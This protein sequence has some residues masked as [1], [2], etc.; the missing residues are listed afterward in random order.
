M[1]RNMACAQARVEAG[2]DWSGLDID[3]CPDSAAYRIT[4]KAW[5]VHCRCARPLPPSP[6][7]QTNPLFGLLHA[8]R[9]PEALQALPRGLET[10]DS[11]QLMTLRTQTQSS[12]TAQ[13][14][15]AA[16]NRAPA[17]CHRQRVDAL[18]HQARCSTMLENS[19][20]SIRGTGLLTV[21]RTSAVS[22]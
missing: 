8:W 20:R 21:G 5:R 16:L 9:G 4:I 10:E 7:E 18:K 3:A 6:S 1:M 15:N 14:T 13:F 19:G 12:S 17:P 2:L 22:A 11:A